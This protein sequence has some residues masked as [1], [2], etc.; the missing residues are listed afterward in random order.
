MPFTAA[1]PALVLPI[2]GKWPKYFSLT[3]LVVGSMAPDFEFFIYF[4]HQRGP[5]HTLLGSLYFNLPLIF[6]AAVLFH[7]IVKKPFIYC[8]PESLGNRFYRMAED[9]WSIATAKN[10]VVFTYSALIGMLSHFFL[11]AFTHPAQLFRELVSFLSKNLFTIRV[12]HILHKVPIY[13]LLYLLITV[14][15]FVVIIYY[16]FRIE[17]S[18]SEK[19][20][21]IGKIKKWIYWTSA[22]ALAVMITVIRTPFISSRQ[23]ISFFDHYGVPFLSGL[24][25]GFLAI[26]LAYN[27]FRE[28]R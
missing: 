4:Q 13:Y 15:G 28:F 7:Y 5:G 9:K 26:S 1:H 22:L 21:N 20:K 3:A 8:L 16:I 11:D 6:L 14:V 19:A 23:G 17:P 12:F 25:L 2:K 24:I 18:E 10:F 27:V